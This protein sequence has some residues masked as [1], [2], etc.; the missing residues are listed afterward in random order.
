MSIINPNIGHCQY[1]VTSY[2]GEL[3]PAHTGLTPVQIYNEATGLTHSNGDIPDNGICQKLNNALVPFDMSLCDSPRNIDM[4][5]Y[6]VMNVNPTTSPGSA[7]A[8][9]ASYAQSLVSGGVDWTIVSNPLDF[10]TISPSGN[11]LLGKPTNLVFPE[12]TIFELM[13]YMGVM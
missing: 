9:T 8:V 12:K 5:G 4:G 13:Y 1:Q 6:R 10:I 11:S 3:Y 7:D 2:N